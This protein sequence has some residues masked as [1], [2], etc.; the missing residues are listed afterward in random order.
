MN[1]FMQ[2][3]ITKKTLRIGLLIAAY[4]LVGFFVLFLVHTLSPFKINAAGWGLLLL[5]VL[6]AL[7]QWIVLL[8]LFNKYSGKDGDRIEM[9]RS[10]WIMAFLPSAALLLL[11]IILYSALGSSVAFFDVSGANF[12]FGLLIILFVMAL[13]GV[14]TMV[15][16]QVLPKRTPS[17]EVVM[18][19]VGN[20]GE[21]TKL[22]SYVKSESAQSGP[23]YGGYGAPAPYPPAYAPAPPAAS[24]AARQELVFPDLVAMDAYYAENAYVAPV[25]DDVTLPRLCSGFNRYLESKGMFYAPETIRSFVSGMACSHLLI[26]EGLSGMG[27]TSLPRYFAEYTGANVNFT[28]VQSSWRDRGDTLGYYNDFTCKFKETPFLRALYKANYETGDV[29]MLVLDE[30]NLSRVEYYF[31]DFLSVLEL[32]KSQWKIELMPVSTGGKLPALLDECSIRIPDNVWF[33]GTAN[34]DDS[35]YAITDKVYDRAMVIDFVRRKDDGSFK[36]EAE[37]I[38][39]GSEKLVAL[40]REAEA[41]QENRLSAADREKF[42]KLSEFMYDTFDV[43]FGNRIMNQIEKFVPVYV[44]CGGTAGKALDLMFSRKVL[45]KLGGRFDDKLGDDLDKLEKLV[46]NM[47]G[48]KDFSETLDVIASLKRKSF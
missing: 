14:V 23:A 15:L 12:A 24:A 45:R 9:K 40:M 25:S 5:L 35:T 6:V 10:Q 17:K 32:D 43:N 34:K 38:K 28:S 7:V 41:R 2:K 30:M 18:K 4:I 26:L 27:K 20:E 19:V 44:A 47:F 39:L 22:A 31:A 3:N 48:R 37:P 33:I 21:G 8:V 46:L 29:N 42:M 16:V 36:G 1:D 11:L 13:L